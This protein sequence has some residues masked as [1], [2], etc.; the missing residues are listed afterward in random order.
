MTVM[1]PPVDQKQTREPQEN[2]LNWAYGVK[3][4]LLT[5]DH[6]RIAI[7]YLVSITI[8]FLI[9]G[10]AASMIRLEL[11]T[12]ESNLLQADSY[13]KTFT[14]HGVIMIFF[15]LIPSIPATLGNFLIPL[16]IGAKDLAFPRLNLTSWYV[17]ISGGLFTLSVAFR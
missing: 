6:K 9:G 5:T 1:S 17:Y 8:F 14:L 10:A 15:F 16:M 7:L 13:N 4:W 11:F 12:P 2:Y 3:S